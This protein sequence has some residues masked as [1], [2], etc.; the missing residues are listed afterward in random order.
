MTPRKLHLCTR[1]SYGRVTPG[2]A[3]AG[4]MSLK[5][6]RVQRQ[7]MLQALVEVQGKAVNMQQ[8]IHALNVSGAVHALTS[9]I[10]EQIGERSRRPSPAAPALPQAEV[11]TLLQADT[12]WAS[13][14]AFLPSC[15]G[16][17]DGGRICIGVIDHDSAGA[18]LAQD[19]PERRAMKKIRTIKEM[20]PRVSSHLNVGTGANSITDADA[21]ETLNH[22]MA[23]TKG[24]DPPAENSVCFRG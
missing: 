18:L 17:S 5:E 13:T 14:T 7:Q 11:P 3:F 24:A 16:R 10:T 23:E 9:R 12:Q 15:A 20:R 21:Q 8:A 22:E 19:S 1:L 4:L 2:S 6:K